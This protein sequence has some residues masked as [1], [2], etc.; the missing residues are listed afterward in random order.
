MNVMSVSEKDLHWSSGYILHGKE[1]SNKSATMNEVDCRIT[2]SSTD[3][4][5]KENPCFKVLFADDKVRSPIKLENNR[6]MVS[7][8]VDPGARNR[9]HFVLHKQRIL[10]FVCDKIGATISSGISYEGEELSHIVPLSKMTLHFDNEAFKRALEQN[11]L[12]GVR[13]TAAQ[14]FI[15]ADSIAT[16]ISDVS[17]SVAC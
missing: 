14:I 6:V 2:I 3:K 4:T 7:D 5:E 12:P 8:D 15:M 9:I 13:D 10:R 1:L 11:S 16:C 17:K